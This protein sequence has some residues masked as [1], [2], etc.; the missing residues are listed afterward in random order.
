MPKKSYT[1]QI[2]SESLTLNRRFKFEQAVGS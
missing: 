2:P 1:I